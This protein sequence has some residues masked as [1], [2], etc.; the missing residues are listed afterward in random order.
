MQEHFGD[1]VDITWKSFLLR[2][3]PKATSRDKFVRYTQ[4]WSRMQE[5]EPRADFR[6]WASDD[7]PPSS[8]LPAQIAHKVVAG[9]WPEAARPMHDRLM[10]AYFT[11]N[12]T[13]SDWQ[14]LADVAAEAGV[15]RDEFQAMAQEQRPSLAQVVIDEH[16]SA[17]EQG[18]TAVPTVLINQVLP[19]PGA[20]D[21]DSYIAW[22]ERILERQ[23]D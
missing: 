14:V 11:E 22:I 23:G 15:D 6:P 16:N 3:E 12:R 1:K 4:G 7:E 9:N 8:S 17:I 21:S 13:I 10:T 20:Q 5:M 2:T 19:V 18:I